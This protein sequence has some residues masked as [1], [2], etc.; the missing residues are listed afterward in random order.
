VD[1]VDPRRPPGYITWEQYEANQQALLDNTAACGADRA[2]V[3]PGKF[4]AGARLGNLRGG[5]SG[6]MTVR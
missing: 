6:G 4:R 2:P 3:R 1:R 5:A